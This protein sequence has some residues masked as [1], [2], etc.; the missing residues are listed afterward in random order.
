MAHWVLSC[1]DCNKDFTH[2]EIPENSASVTDPFTGSA[3][4]PEFPVG[5]F[6]VL[7]PNCKKISVYQRYELTYRGS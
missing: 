1:P 6:S 2:S 5:G 4:K 3:V 7:C